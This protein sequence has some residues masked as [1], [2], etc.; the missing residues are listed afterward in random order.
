MSGQDSFKGVVVKTTGNVYLVETEKGI[1][2][3]SI[4][5]KFRI[6]G[7]KTTNPS[8][9]GDIVD[10]EYD[11]KSDSYVIYN[12]HPRRNYLIRR[13]V[14]LSKQYHI[15]AA[16]I[17]QCVVMASIR[18][19][20]TS[21]E[22]VDRMLVSAE[23]YGIPSIILINKI[24]LLSDTELEE[25]EGWKWTYSTAGY[26][27]IP[28]SISDPRNSDRI[29]QVFEHKT[30][31][32]SGHSGAGKS[33]LLNS[34]SP[35]LGIQTSAVSEQHSQG[36]H[37]TTFAEMH[38]MP[39]DGKIIDTPGIR[40]LGVVDIESSELNHFFPEFFKLK[41]KC[42]FN[43]CIHLNEPNCAVKE[44]IDKR[45]IAYSRYLSYLSI[46]ESDQNYR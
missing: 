10:F 31:V 41:P 30:S 46:L 15:I 7:I 12:I 6:K 26:T 24:D 17:D 20:K 36:K 22:F 33:T 40:G 23:A 18:A 39:F 32:I 34:L 2:T 9:V 29:K 4:K 13:S 21:M 45:E 37:T 16:N 28:I 25:L 11:S 3:C 1:Q 5:G 35:G 27:I 14:N 42:K 43:N 8:A 19:P 38:N 44:A